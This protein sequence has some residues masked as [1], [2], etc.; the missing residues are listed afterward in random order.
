MLKVNTAQP[1]L[2][3]QYSLNAGKTWQPLKSY[4][5]ITGTILITTT[6]YDGS[7]RSRAVKVDIK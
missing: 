4:A 5:K 6:S 7:R 2:K 1:G 3:L